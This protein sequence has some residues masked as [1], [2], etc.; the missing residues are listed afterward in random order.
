LWIASSRLRRSCNA[1]QRQLQHE[2]QA[3]LSP[4]ESR[5]RFSKFALEI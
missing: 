1:G 4:S 2:E 3:G 5:A